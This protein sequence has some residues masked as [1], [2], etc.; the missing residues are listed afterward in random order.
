[1]FIKQEYVR[2]QGTI[3]AW[4]MGLHFH[5]IDNIIHK[6]LIFIYSYWQKITV[7]Q[8]VDAMYKNSRS[9]SSNNRLRINSKIHGFLQILWDLTLNLI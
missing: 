6:I 8:C 5:F 4:F 2:E 1:M 9:F 7:A 3:L